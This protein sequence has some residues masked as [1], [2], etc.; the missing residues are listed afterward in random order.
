MQGH[1]LGGVEQAHQHLHRLRRVAIAAEPQRDQR[2]VVGPHG[3]VVVAH[4]VVAGFPLIQ[5]ANPPAV[6]AAGGQQLAGDRTGRGLAG[7]AGPEAVA[8][9]GGA[10]LAGLTLAVKGQ[11]IGAD[12]L[13]PEGVVEAS[14]QQAGLLQ[15]PLSLGVVAEMPLDVSHRLAGPIAVGLHLAE[16]DRPLRETTVG[17]VH[18]VVGIL[19]ALVAQ[20]PLSGALIPQEAIRRA[21]LGVANPVH[22]RLQGGLQVADEGLI[23]AADQVVAR[24]DQ[25][26]GSGID[27]AVVLGKGHLA[28]GG[29]LPQPGLVQHLAGLRIARRVGVT[30]LVLRQEAQD[31]TGQPGFEQQHL[32][33]RDQAIATKRT[34][35]PGNAGVG[36]EA[37]VELAGQQM[38]IRGGTRDPGIEGGIVAA[39]AGGQP[40]GFAE[41]LHRRLQGRIKGRLRRRWLT[42]AI[43]VEVEH[44]A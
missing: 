43:G 26:Q 8:G 44:Q 4:R 22:R 40:V 28:Q 38:H 13:A 34:T 5:G 23:A 12:P 24:Q 16:G 9:I 18:G 21:L 39:H 31:A 35:E 25:K 27:A 42:A 20:A 7:Q 32:P 15:Q 36:V 33:G 10:H 2:V 6:E 17:M 37:V 3:T 41:A 11:G 30:G 1:G 19:P 29:H 14:P